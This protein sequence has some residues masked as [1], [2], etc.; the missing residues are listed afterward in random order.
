MWRIDN[1]AGAMAGTREKQLRGLGMTGAGR[2]P[3]RTAGLNN[4]GPRYRDL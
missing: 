3:E 2:V 1:A 4:G